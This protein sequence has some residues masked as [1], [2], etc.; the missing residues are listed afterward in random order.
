MFQL[1]RDPAVSEHLQWHPHESIDDSLAFIRDASELWERRT[2]FFLGVFDGERETLLGSTG[3]SSIDR[4][5]RRGEV[6]T[7]LGVPH[8][9][10]GY[11]RFVKAAVFA[12]GFEV[13]GLHRLELLVK[14]SNVRS[15]RAN[16]AITGVIDEGLQ[17]ARLWSKGC[18]HD[19]H[20]LAITR[21]SYDA[22]ALPPVTIT[23][24]VA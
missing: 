23:G 18:C 2:A 6:G 19:A 20:M 16:L 14:A 13:L 17:H 21:N 5:N 4:G 9:G 8:Q 22:S 12:F 1:A 11:N 7:W 10:R 15:Y 24:M 3:I